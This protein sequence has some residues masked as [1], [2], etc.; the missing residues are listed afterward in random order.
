MMLEQVTANPNPRPFHK[1]NISQHA[2]IPQNHLLLLFQSLNHPLTI[3]TGK[4]SA[5]FAPFPGTPFKPNSFQ[6]KFP[7]V[8]N[9]FS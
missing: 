6:N 9:L 5:D 8:L 2:C 3:R 7:F 4:V 1:E